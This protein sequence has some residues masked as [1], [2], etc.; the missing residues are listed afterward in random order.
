MS[1]GDDKEN[2]RNYLSLKHPNLT[3][4]S[5]QI[6]TLKP[7]TKVLNEARMQG[8][9]HHKYK[10]TQVVTNRRVFNT[11]IFIYNLLYQLN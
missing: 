3:A 6:R 4:Q 10:I 7:G 2:I 5:F 9:K 8:K 1:M 11:A